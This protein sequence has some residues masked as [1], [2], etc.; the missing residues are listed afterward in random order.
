MPLNNIQIGLSFGSF[1]VLNNLKFFVM[2][3]PNTEVVLEEHRPITLNPDSK[4][5]RC[6]SGPK[7]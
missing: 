1:C 5:P 6:T 7:C 3:Q 4:L 2:T